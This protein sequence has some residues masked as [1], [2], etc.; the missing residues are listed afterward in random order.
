M[1]GVLGRVL[2]TLASHDH[3]EPVIRERDRETPMTFAYGTDDAEQTANDPA[4]S[5]RTA[6]RD[7]LT[8]EA[9]AA[10]LRRVDRAAGEEDEDD[11][12]DAAATQELTG[13]DIFEAVTVERVPD[14]A[15]TSERMHALTEATVPEEP[16]TLES[17]PEATGT[18]PSLP[19][20]PESTPTLPA[21]EAPKTPA[22]VADAAPSKS[23]SKPPSKPASKPPSTM[24]T[25]IAPKSMGV[26]SRKHT[27]L[28]QDLMR[29]PVPRMKDLAGALGPLRD[30]PRISHLDHPPVSP[31]VRLDREDRDEQKLPST[32]RGHVVMPREA[33][34]ITE[35]VHGATSPSASQG[36]R[37][38]PYPFAS[39]VDPE[40]EVSTQPLTEPA[41]L[42]LPL[43]S[44]L[45]SLAAP[46]SA[47]D[48]VPEA[49]QSRPVPLARLIES[50]IQSSIESSIQSSIA[51]SVATVS[52]GARPTLESAQ[53]IV[54]PP[55]KPS[56]PWAHAP[57]A[58]PDP[59]MNAPV[60][61]LVLPDMS[62]AVPAVPTFDPRLAH[63]DY[64]EGLARR[65]QAERAAAQKVA[66]PA[67]HVP[68]VTDSLSPDASLGAGR[69]RRSRA[70]LIAFAAS[71]VLIAA[72]LFCAAV[73]MLRQAP[74]SAPTATFAAQPRAT[75]APVAQLQRGA[76]LA[77]KPPVST[78]PVNAAPVAGVTKE[79][80]SDNGIPT[81][82]VDLLPKA[83]NTRGILHVGKP[84]DG[85]RVF[86]DGAVVGNGAG[87]YE[88]VCGRHGVKIGSQDRSRPI[89]V[90]CGGEL[91]LE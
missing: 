72:T 51:S 75:H 77:A 84:L 10:L 23:P 60:R 28:F 56:A 62:G 58:R 80:S 2:E 19:P 53:P 61:P 73:L 49:L 88:L 64:A 20:S 25:V 57:E 50:S 46:R 74:M 55:P 45:M 6:R 35:P 14:E 67:R 32:R 41:S 12:A 1:R 24:P 13:D 76:K 48:T 66:P 91:T 21:S 9:A 30:A 27:D 59:L 31:L 11:G 26:P 18:L 33:E 22:L 82:S 63:L 17:L 16:K 40:L 4:D 81:L 78:V 7:S 15:L 3:V 90:P 42:P 44:P 79:S 85:H 5:T 34:P 89:V 38:Q 52:E 69:R 68:T 70:W 39:P 43:V 86:V 54:V 29:A 8:E 83:Q 87:D 65:Q 36:P 37:T 47:P 71:A